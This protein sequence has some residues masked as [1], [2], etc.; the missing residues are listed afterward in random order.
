MDWKGV[1]G[2]HTIRSI[3]KWSI[4]KAPTYYKNV[5][6]GFFK[7]VWHTVKNIATTAS[8]ILTKEKLEQNIAIT[9]AITHPRQTFNDTKAAVK[10]WSKNLAS[11]NP[12]IAGN[13]L[14]KDS[15]LGWK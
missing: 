2:T 4:D 3:I 12:A 5:F 14:V 8:P 11:S 7:A 15:S 1:R 10:Q 9:Q 13:A 6:T